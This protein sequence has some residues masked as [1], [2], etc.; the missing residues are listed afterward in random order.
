MIKRNEYRGCVKAGILKEDWETALDNENADEGAQIAELIR[1]KYRT[2]IE[3]ENG[4]RKV[5]SAL[6]RKGFSY[7]AVRDA[8]KKYSEELLYGE[9]FE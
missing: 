6:I 2:K 8:L 3:S 4:V 7:G 5:Y 9:D 1:K